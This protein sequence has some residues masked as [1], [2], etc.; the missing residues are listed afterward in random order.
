M[1]WYRK[2]TFET[3]TKK[4]MI[5]TPPYCTRYSVFRFCC[6]AGPRRNMHLLDW[7][8]QKLWRL[9][10]PKRTLLRNRILKKE[11]CICWLIPYSGR[12]YEHL[13][14][15]KRLPAMTPDNT[16]RRSGPLLSLSRQASSKNELPLKWS[17][18]TTSNHRTVVK[19]CRKCGRS[20]KHEMFSA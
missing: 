20:S 11:V 16:Q 5:F 7:L 17:G 8:L 15:M 10:F 3:L 18:Q 9:I 14:K 2:A 12:Q 19:Y 1:F 6:K 13:P 4:K